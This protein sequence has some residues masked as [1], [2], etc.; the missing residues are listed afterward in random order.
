MQ[1]KVGTPQ[2][3]GRP[4]RAPKH[5]PPRSP[6]SP[7]F[8]YLLLFAGG[9]EPLGSAFPAPWRGLGSFFSGLLRGA[10]CGAWP[11]TA[12]SLRFTPR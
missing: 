6:D 3:T 8:A 11:D 7:R 2:T 5:P 10:Q 12:R 1:E 4:G 9:G